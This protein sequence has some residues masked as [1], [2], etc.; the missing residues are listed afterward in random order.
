MGKPLQF[1]A[2]QFLDAIPGTG[3][4][5]AAIAKRVG[6]AWHTA[7][8]Y[9]ENHP[10]V[11]AA[12]EDECESVLDLAEAKTIEAIRNGDTQMI[13]YYLSTKGKRRG[14]TERT[15][16]TGADNEPLTVRYVNDWRVAITRSSHGAESG[17]EGDSAEPLRLAVGGPPLAQDDDGATPGD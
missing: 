9:I 10:T 7:K 14:Y 13:R 5:I 17:L 15:E 8:K 2:Q 6:C 16:I 12:Y 4:I 3:G 11:H 1:S